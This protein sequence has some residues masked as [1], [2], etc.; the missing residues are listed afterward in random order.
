MTSSLYIED[1]GFKQIHFISK[2]NSNLLV[3]AALV[4]HVG[5]D[6][7]AT[8]GLNGKELGHQLVMSEMELPGTWEY[9]C[10]AFCPSWVILSLGSLLA[11][12]QSCSLI[13]SSLVGNNIG[14][15]GA[16]AL[17]LML[18]KNMAL[19]ELW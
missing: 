11:L 8:S 18:E 15:V 5:K 9:V 3:G 4:H 14:S 7:Q 17:A 19:E 13:P 1:L 16:Q 2:T 10:H 6:S 12:T